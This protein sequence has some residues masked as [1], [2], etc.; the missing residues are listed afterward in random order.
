MHLFCRNIDLLN[1]RTTLSPSSSSIRNPLTV[2]EQSDEVE[3]PRYVENSIQH[4]E[5]VP[6]DNGIDGQ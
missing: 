5:I 3:E 4:L 2:V 6:A 1:V